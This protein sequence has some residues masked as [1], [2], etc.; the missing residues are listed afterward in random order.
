MRPDPA[1]LGRMR[2]RVIAAVAGALAAGALLS[3]CVRGPERITPPPPA[4]VPAP[5]P[6]AKVTAPPVDPQLSSVGDTLNQLDS[7]LA[8]ADEA[9]ADAD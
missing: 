5:S 6:S 3:G 7:Q 9:P 2:R 4:T 1:T 8:G